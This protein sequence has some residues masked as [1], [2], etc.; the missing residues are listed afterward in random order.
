LLANHQADGRGP[1]AEKHCYVLH[2]VHCYSEALLTQNGDC[3]GVSR[4]RATF[5]C[6][7]RTCPRS[8]R[9]V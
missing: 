9:G 7:W 8:L 1:Q 6:E 5:N 3:V 2:K 4:Q